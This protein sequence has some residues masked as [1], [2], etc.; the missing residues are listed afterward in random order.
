MVEADTSTK[1]A[2]AFHLVRA[3][4]AEEALEYIQRSGDTIQIADRQQLTTIQ[5]RHGWFSSRASQ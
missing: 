3:S 1:H 2:P 5:M 4:S